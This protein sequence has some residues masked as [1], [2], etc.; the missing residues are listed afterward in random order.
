MQDM[1]ALKNPTNLS[2]WRTWEGQAYQQSGFAALMG[3]LFALM[4]AFVMSLS[5]FGG[6]LSGSVG[7]FLIGVILYFGVS[8]AL[9][10]LAVLRLNAW[11]R[12]NPWTPPS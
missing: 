5:L 2:S 9:I 10:G 4:L 8:F 3:A 12:A 1:R 7:P 6:K 11:K